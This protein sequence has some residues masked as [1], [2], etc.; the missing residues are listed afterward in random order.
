MSVTPLT[1]GTLEVQGGPSDLPIIMQTAGAK[2]G[3]ISG[4]LGSRVHALNHCP[5]QPPQTGAIQWGRFSAQGL[6][7]PMGGKAQSGRA[8]ECFLEG[9]P[10][11]DL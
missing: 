8:R 1:K 7:K 10:C 2:S 11:R 9:R 5:E 6:W 4:Q 3:F